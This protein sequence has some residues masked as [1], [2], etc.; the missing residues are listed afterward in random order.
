M[1]DVVNNYGIVGVISHYKVSL[2]KTSKVRDLNITNVTNA[3]KMLS[4]NEDI[5]D[6]ELNELSQ[7]ELFKVDLATKLHEN[8]II[9]GNMSNMLNYKDQ[10]YIKKLL[11]KLYNDYHKSIVVIDENVKVFMN[12]VKRIFVLNGKQIVYETDDFYDLNLYNYTKIPKIVDFITYVNK[13]TKR[14]NNNVDIYELI[15]DIFRSVS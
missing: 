6:K 10:E 5:L 2:D 9:I 8:I 12:L 13:D 7:D 14:L 3:F 1:K 15:K 4:L 11:L